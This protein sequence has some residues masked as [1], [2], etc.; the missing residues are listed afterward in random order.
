LEWLENLKRDGITINLVVE[1]VVK[2]SNNQEK[3]T[4]FL[5]SHHYKLKIGKQINLL[6]Y[7]VHLSIVLE[8]NKR[9]EFVSASKYGNLDKEW[10]KEL[11][12]KF[13]KIENDTITIH[14]AF[15]LPIFSTNNLYESKIQ[16][17]PRP[18]KSNELAKF[19][20][21]NLGNLE[22]FRSK[23]KEQSFVVSY[24]DKYNQSEFSMRFLSS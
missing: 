23:I 10:S 18:A 16:I 14:D 2:Y 17:L 15:E 1:G 8:N 24:Y 22:D 21:E 20:T 12:D 11:E 19:V 5:L 7:P 4:V 9:I 3:L 13:Y 6:N